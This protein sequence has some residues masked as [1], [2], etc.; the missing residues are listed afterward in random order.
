MSKEQDENK[1]IAEEKIKQVNDILTTRTQDANWLA[2]T[3]YNVSRGN[4]NGSGSA[5]TPPVG[6]EFHFS[7]GQAQV[8]GKDEK[9]SKQE[10]QIK[11]LLDEASTAVSK[12]QDNDAKNVTDNA[13]ENNEVEK[14]NNEVTNLK[15]DIDNSKSESQEIQAKIEDAEHQKAV[16]E[17][18]HKAITETKESLQN[19]NPEQDDSS[20]QNAETAANNGA[21]VTG[22]TSDTDNAEA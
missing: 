9:F 6:T 15:K 4:I 14:L 2:S 22:E 1:K 17:E 20:Q 7:D 8:T 19:S 11:N 21:T 3:E 10:E 5:V 12:A 18:Q 16:K 13:N